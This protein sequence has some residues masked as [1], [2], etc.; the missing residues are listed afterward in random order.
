[1]YCSHILIYKPQEDKYASVKKQIIEAKG[2]LDAL[3]KAVENA[4]NVIKK[5]GVEKV[6][7]SFSM[8]R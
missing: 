3:N 8:S 1:M 6:Y 4:C 7:L 5:D 2:D